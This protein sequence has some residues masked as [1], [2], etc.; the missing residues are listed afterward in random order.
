M[1]IKLCKDKLITDEIELDNCV[2]AI[3]KES[4]ISIFVHKTF[5]TIFI[6]EYGMEEI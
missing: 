6:F 2:N 3:S 4:S 1:I 5:Y